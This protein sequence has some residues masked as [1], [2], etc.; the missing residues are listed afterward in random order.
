[1]AHF[2]TAKICVAKRLY[3]WVLVPPNDPAASAMDTLQ[4]GPK[5]S[6][7]ISEL[8]VIITIHAHHVMAGEAYIL[9]TKIYLLQR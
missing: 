2:L 3:R 4:S 1:M 8:L 5:M 9:K 6:N 7:I